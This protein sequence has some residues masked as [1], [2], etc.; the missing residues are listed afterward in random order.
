MPDK[1]SSYPQLTAADL[2]DPTVFR[3]NSSIQF[4]YSQIDQIQTELA[5]L[6]K[7][8]AGVTPTTPVTLS[9]GTLTAG[10]VVVAEGA[11]PPV[12]VGPGASGLPL[13]GVTGADPKFLGT[14]DT[15]DLTNGLVKA[16]NGVLGISGTVQVRNSAGTGIS[17]F[18]FSYGLVT[19]FAP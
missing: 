5:A 12:G 4:L 17:T 8:R 13:I 2:K 11:S 7:T 6:T 15:L 19:N 14:G 1:Q 3:L 9:V 16:P 18:T 10:S